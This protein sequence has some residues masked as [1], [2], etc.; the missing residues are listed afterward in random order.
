MIICIFRQNYYS[1]MKR[2]R[3]IVARWLTLRTS[4]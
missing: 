2:S 1:R 3:R 4:S